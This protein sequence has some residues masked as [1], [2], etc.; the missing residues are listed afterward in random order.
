MIR[1][2][3]KA[4]KITMTNVNKKDIFGPQERRNEPKK[5]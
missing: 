4:T 2:I 3:K 1:E 5:F